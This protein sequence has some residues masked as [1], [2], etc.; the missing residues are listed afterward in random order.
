MMRLC[1]EIAHDVQRRRLHALVASM[2]L[3]LRESDDTLTDDVRQVL[4]AARALRELLEAD[5][6][7]DVEIFSRCPYGAAP[8]GRS[9]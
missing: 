6:I 2:L 4:A 9:S 3:G 5:P 1:L 7:G 8:H